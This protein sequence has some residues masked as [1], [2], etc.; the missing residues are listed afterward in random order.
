[1]SMIFLMSVKVLLFAEVTIFFIW[2]IL[3]TVTSDDLRIL[4]VLSISLVCVSSIITPK[5]FPDLLRRDSSRIDIGII[6]TPH[7]L[8]PTHCVP[9]AT[10]GNGIVD[11]GYGASTEHVYAELGSSSARNRPRVGQLRPRADLNDCSE[12]GYSMI[13]PSARKISSSDEVNLFQSSIM[14]LYYTYI[15]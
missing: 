14:L 15:R 2:L 10:H 8:P 4:Y 12:D 11:S 5:L 9:M 13:R 7:P 6:A 3:M 1:M